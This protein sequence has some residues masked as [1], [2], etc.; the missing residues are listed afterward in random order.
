M[1]TFK[2]EYKEPN[3]KSTQEQQKSVEAV[4]GIYRGI[5]AVRLVDGQELPL[6]GSLF[7]NELTTTL[8]LDLAAFDEQLEGF[9]EENIRK[10]YEQS[11]E[12]VKDWLEKIGSD[13]DPYIF[14]ICYGVQQKMHKLLEIDPNTPTNS[15]ERQKMYQGQRPPKLSELK[16][17]TEC[18]ERA[19]FGQYLLQRVG[20]ESAYVSGITMQDVRD[21]DEF[22]EDHSFIILKHPTKPGSS[23]IFDIARPRSQNNVPR[24]LETD[25]PFNYDLLN[26]KEDLLVGATEVLQGGRLWFGV[27]KP[28]AGQHKTIEKPERPE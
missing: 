23:L 6:G 26:G 12:G 5:W 10:A 19:A 11:K 8:E 2:P 21:T 15:F 25:V 20:A 1:E 24:V 3:A 7:S 22:P 18:A 9:T 17:K 28:V 4:R 27:G 16:G 14:F 13:M